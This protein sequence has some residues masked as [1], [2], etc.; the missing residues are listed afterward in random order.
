MRREAVQSQIIQERRNCLDVSGSQ[1]QATTV[2]ERHARR[3]NM[4]GF[5]KFARLHQSVMGE[6]P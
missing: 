1:V 2:V 5:D 4:I 6:V 3:E